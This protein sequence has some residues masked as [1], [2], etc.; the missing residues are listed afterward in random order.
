MRLLDATLMRL[1][2]IQQQS[3]L[4]MMR[5]GERGIPATVAMLGFETRP[6]FLHPGKPL[7]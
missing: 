3:S 7:R 4:R 2:A 5:S 1:L 6:S